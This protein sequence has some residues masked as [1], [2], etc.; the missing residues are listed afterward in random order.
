MTVEWLPVDLTSCLD[1]SWRRLAKKGEAGAE[2]ALEEEVVLLPRVRL[3]PVGVNRWRL[4]EKGEAM[5]L[6]NGE[7]DR[8][9]R[10]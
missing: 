9:V 3:V 6:A 8:R 10:C 1:D 7:A 4:V 2:M 5:F